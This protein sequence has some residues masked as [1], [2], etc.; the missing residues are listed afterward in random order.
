MRH[1]LYSFSSEFFAL[2]ESLLGDPLDYSVPIDLALMD[3]EEEV[4]ISVSAF[5]LDALT[6]PPSPPSPPSLQDLWVPPLSFDD[7]LGDIGGNAF[8]SRSLSPLPSPGDM[9]VSKDSCDEEVE[10]LMSRDLY[11]YE[12]MPSSPSD[13]PGPDDIEFWDEDFGG[14]EEYDGDLES[15]SPSLLRYPDV[16]GVDCEACDFHRAN[17]HRYCALCYMRLTHDMIYREGLWV[18]GHLRTLF[19]ITNLTV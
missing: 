4:H 17:G 11:C 2:A 19:Y 14:I 3:G 1:A 12:D 9:D 7:D 6:P 18:I 5:S 13:L 8:V 10:A 15:M 16:P